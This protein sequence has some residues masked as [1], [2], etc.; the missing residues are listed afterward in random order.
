MIILRCGDNG[1]VIGKALSLCS[2]SV[3]Y[4]VRAGFTSGGFGRFTLDST[5]R[6]PLILLG[7]GPLYQ[8]QVKAL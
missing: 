5:Y 6:F 8:S 4:L 2:W 1:H 7:Q 3:A